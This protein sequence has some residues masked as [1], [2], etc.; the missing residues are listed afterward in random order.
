MSQYPFLRDMVELCF[1]RGCV[2]CRRGDLAA[3]LFVCGPV[4]QLAFPPT[5]L[6]RFA[7]GTLF[8][9]LTTGVAAMAHGTINRI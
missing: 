3:V 2:F 4:C 6:D 8:Q 7:A 5:V 9:I 1:L